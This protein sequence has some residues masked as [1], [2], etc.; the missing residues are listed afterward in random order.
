MYRRTTFFFLLKIIK[1][2]LSI[3][4]LSLIVKNF[5]VGL[6]MDAWLVSLSVTTIIGL[7]VWGSMNEVFRSRFIILKENTGAEKALQYSQSL[8]YYVIFFSFVLVILIEIFPSFVVSAMAPDFKPKDQEFLVGILR[9]VAPWLIF[10]QLSLI[11][12]SILNAYEVFYVPEFASFF[13]QVVNIIIIYFLAGKFGINCLVISLY[14]SVILLSSLLLYRIKKLK[15]RLFSPKVP[16]FKGFKFFFIASIPFFIPYFMGQANGWAEKS[17]ATGLGIGSVSILDLSKKLPD[18]FNGILISVTLT[19]LT[20]I[21]TKAFANNEKKI[22]ETEFTKSYQLSLFS[23]TVFI[24][25]FINASNPLLHLLYGRGPISEKD[26]LEV[27][28]LSKFYSIT[29]FSIFSYI[30]FGVC[31]LSINMGKLYALYGASA[32]VMSLLT[33]YFFIKF[34]GLYVFPVSCCISHLTFA[35]FM[36]L[37]YPFGKKKILLVT[38]QYYILVFLSVVLGI[39]LFKLFS[40]EGQNVFL[41]HV[42]NIII[43]FVIS[44]VLTS[45]LGKVFKIPEVSILYNYAVNKIFG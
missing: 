39:F 3:I 9:L 5:G 33:N 45:F 32:Q 31:M 14:V 30:I 21:L 1:F 42:I 27:I 37:K 17:L 25:F 7:A 16:S 12:T 34:W 38:I 19:I 11:L 15:L 24:V 20:P 8:I 2:P 26:M 44:I 35:F 22:Y 4:Y 36:F 28:R 6:D 23:L 18:V 10:N 40:F 41:M 29:V 13:T 43:S